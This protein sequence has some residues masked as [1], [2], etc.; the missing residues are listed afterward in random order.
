MHFLTKDLYFPPVEEASYEGI[1][2]V[3]GD[4]STERL[5][6]AYRKGIFPWFNEDEPILWWAPSERMV[7]VPMNYKVSKSIRNLLNQNKFQVTF[8]QKFEEVIRN[9]QQ[10]VRS[11]QEGTWITDEIIAS[12]TELHKMGYAKSVE[13]WQN[14]ELVGGLYGVDLGHVFCGESMFSKVPN[15]SKIA[16]V[17]LIKQLKE[18]QYKLLDCQV[19]N[20][21]LERLG[22][23]EISRA[24]FMKVLQSGGY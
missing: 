24:T 21:H 23:F 17:S 16:F 6:L 8:N 15:A 4:L 9:C 3:G 12:Y 7:V 2:A 14:G 5:L 1:L 18:Q 22:A 10:I 20:D 13:V 19:H 11:G